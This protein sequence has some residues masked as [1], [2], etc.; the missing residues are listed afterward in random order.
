MKKKIP[1]TIGAS[2][3]TGRTMRV[4]NW[5]M[6]IVIILSVPHMLKGYGSGGLIQREVSGKVTNEQGEGL[7]GVSIVVSGTTTGTSTVDDGTFKIS[8]PGEHAVLVF[9]YVGYVDEEVEIGTR[10]IVNI[11]L[12]LASALDEVVVVGFATQRKANVTGS[13]SVIGSRELESRP[14]TNVAQALQGLATG[15]EIGQSS[16]GGSLESAP[17]INIRGRN[18]I[19]QGSN[20]GP[21]ILIDG[22]EGNPNHLSPNDI[23]SISI[24]K[25]AAASS[26]YGSR[27]P[28]GVI[29]ITTKRGTKG[30]PIITY[31]NSFRNSSPINFPE[32]ADSYRWALF[33]NDASRNSGAPDFVGP[34]RM[35]RIIDYMAG[36]SG[37]T[38]IP[39]DPGNP[40]R[41]A[42][43]S[44]EGNDNHDWWTSVFRS[45][46]PAN[47]HTLSMR[48]GGN[49]MNYYL[50]GNVLNQTGMLRLGGD[51]LT[52]Y[53][54]VVNL[55]SKIA[56]WL[57]LGY[58]GKF[59]R[60]DY[61]RP[62]DF[63]GRYMQY[64]SRTQPANPLYDPNGHLFDVTTDRLSIIAVGGRYNR[65]IDNSS[66]QFRLIA[67]PL[68]G[69]TLQGRFYYNLGD[70]F[71][72]TVRLT[73]YAHDVEGNPYVAEPE[74]YVSEYIERYDYISQDYFARYDKSI[75]KHGFQVMAGF[76]SE[77]N[78]FRNASATR[79][80]M[81][82]RENPTI[83]VT[84][85]QALDGSTIP[86]SVSGG[87]NDWATMGY[88]G[89]INY[90]YDERYFVELN[91]RYD[92]TSR[93]RADK[94]WGSFPSFSAGWN[95]AGE[96][97][98]KAHIKNISQLK[99]RGSY[100]VLGNQNTSSIY[101]T[102][103]TMPV[104]TAN[105]GWIINNARPNTA[106]AP[107]LVSAVLTWENIR[108]WNIGIDV[109]ALRNRL[110][111][112]FDYF[113]RYT[114]D[115]VG[116]APQLPKVLGTSVPTT[117]NTDMKSYGFEAEVSWNDRL[118]NGLGYRAKFML[119]DARSV[120][121]RYPNPTNNFWTYLAGQ[122]LGNIWGFTTIG[123]AKTQAEMDAHLAT[124]P[125]GGQQ[126][127]GSDWSAGD[128]MF[129]D[130]DGDGRVDG[131]T[132]TMDNQ[133]DYSVI[134]NSTPR[135]R[136]GFDLG[137]D[138]KGLDL[139]MFFQGVMKRDY[140]N[141]GYNFWGSGPNV[142]WSTA[143][144][145]HLDYFRDDP[146]H[147]LGLNLDSYYPRPYF[148]GDY[149]SSGRN[150]A[151][152]TRYLQNAAYIRLKN[153]T[154]GYT[155]PQALT[156]KAKIE[157]VRLFA[158]GENLWTFTKISELFD[159]EL[160][161]QGFTGAVYPFSRVV[162]LGLNV[163]F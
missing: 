71:A 73:T 108:A 47:E 51:D 36:K 22:A 34:E 33:I 151:A 141:G 161:D 68:P 95:I 66:N 87:E 56:D 48:G 135:F 100:G 18:T 38:N 149:E 37:V 14:V 46:S 120:V 24:L 9:S 92:G 42:G 150:K 107:G 129:K 54:A 125:N 23:E 105:G 102:Y 99:L 86:P 55:E 143:Y 29:L 147:P 8:V 144:I 98:W 78:K 2:R 94:R 139:R 79:H 84:T 61:D 77:Y 81:I 138:W 65:I 126:Y 110:A 16:Y 162:S 90:S 75:D 121:L 57:T 158:S 69:L 19:G 154:A 35:Q 101:P 127:L 91:Y 82:I 89:R 64:M 113:T 122:E 117:N 10:N 112:T 7:P 17:T 21:L 124:L 59:S 80:G 72:R 137:A 62:S 104:N 43:G 106:S 41:W 130:I 50:S 115:M 30:G 45:S 58:N 60:E 134:G 146:D 128:I 93:F 119:S 114:E 116:P 153:V 25:D 39:P 26:I 53:N 44:S 31:N 159:P 12:K 136:F 15:L 40:V 28:F 11:S 132:G 163:T 96:E 5:W 97:F 123:I 13:V 85:G 109:E 32:T 140:F 20:G 133:G 156:K 155:L 145:P 67:D 152:Q 63:E 27:A 1:K 76:Q 74:N 4:A 131:G 3:G 6:M 142:W 148:N 157:R 103:V 111:F 83:N 52:R 70:R 49:A 88:F 118:S 160:L